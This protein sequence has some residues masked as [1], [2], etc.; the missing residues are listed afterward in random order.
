MYILH[1]R[2]AQG[3]TEYGH[4]DHASPAGRLIG[5]LKEDFSSFV[6]KKFVKETLGKQVCFLLWGPGRGGGGVWS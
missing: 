6:R 3:V 4:Y 1:G 5:L 2:Q